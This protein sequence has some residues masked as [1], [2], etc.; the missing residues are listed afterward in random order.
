MKKQN[1]E[2][3]KSLEINSDLDFNFAVKLNPVLRWILVLP[4]GIAGVLMI[5]LAGG[6]MVNFMLRG[7]AADSIIAIIVTGLFGIVKFA[8]FLFSMVAMAPVTRQ[9]KLRTGLALAFIPISFPFL[10][11]R[12]INNMGYE[13]ESNMLALTLA[14]VLIGVALAL[15]WIRQETNKPLPE[16]EV[17]APA[18]EAPTPGETQL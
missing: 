1:K 10:I 9:N 11:E 18:E 4:V 14:M 8:Y 6:W 2:K 17:E 7:M 16:P 12:W 15:F 13:L 5:Q 3:N